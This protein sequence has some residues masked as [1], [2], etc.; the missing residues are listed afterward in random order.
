MRENL[1]QT[2]K[3]ADDGRKFIDYDWYA[4]GIPANVKTAENVYL[5]TSYSFAGFHSKKDE[6]LIIGEG[7]G[8]YDRASFVAGKDGRIHVGTHTALN[9]TTIIA[10]EYVEIGNH[11]LLAWGSVITDSWSVSLDTETRRKILHLASQDLNRQLLP[12]D[13]PSPV[14][15]QDNVWIGF[16][17]VI[18]PGVRL[19]RGSVIGCKTIIS[20]D[21][22]PYAIM[23]GNPARL[24]RFLEP[25]DTE[26]A[27]K[28]AFMNG[29][30]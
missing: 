8:T 2:G 21:V 9:G 4:G 28:L 29:L 11:C 27:I 22:P 1:V 15:I 23:V 19:G 3:I 5:D 13:K 17:S 30:K 24:I 25:N 10:N 14:I 16:D 7:S 26:G 12:T 18:L 20:K 6:A